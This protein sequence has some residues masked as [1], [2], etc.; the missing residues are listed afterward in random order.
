METYEQNAL[1][2]FDIDGADN[3]DAYE[4]LMNVDVTDDEQLKPT[5]FSEME[6]KFVNAMIY[7]K[8][9]AE[10]DVYD[11][12]C[13]ALTCG[14]LWKMPLPY[15]DALKMF[16]AA[17]ANYNHAKDICKIK[18]LCPVHLDTVYEM[19]DGNFN[20][21]CLVKDDQFRE[22]W[23]DLYDVRHKGMFPGCTVKW[24]FPVSYF[25]KEDSEGNKTRG[26]TLA[27]PEKNPYAEITCTAL[28][29]AGF[30]IPKQIY[31][32]FF[33]QHANA[34]GNVEGLEGQF[35]SHHLSDLIR[36]FFDFQNE[37]AFKEVLAY[38]GLR[39]IYAFDEND[40]ANYEWSDDDNALIATLANPNEFPEL[41]MSEKGQSYWRK[42]GINKYRLFNPTAYYLPMSDGSHHVSVYAD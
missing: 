22:S 18:I 30:K 16:F 20:K 19:A 37:E 2:R 35:D 31:Y 12:I 13:L 28:D 15:N 26:I 38:M 14:D 41:E 27:A 36:A 11:R 42:L 5:D 25:T 10:D 8:N 7:S 23:V 32:K 4:Y 39:E 17:T 40:R 33:L 9:C 21:L 1:F 34:T 29:T 3:S 6:P 24:R